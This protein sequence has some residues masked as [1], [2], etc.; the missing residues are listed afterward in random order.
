MGV[1]I[2]GKP[3]DRIEG[4]LILLETDCSSPLFSSLALGLAIS[5]SLIKLIRAINMKKDECRMNNGR[6]EGDSNLGA[7]PM[8]L[9]NRVGP[10]EHVS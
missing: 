5:G 1:M 3:P 9:C 6:Y 2:I 8:E 7:L 10:L 4:S